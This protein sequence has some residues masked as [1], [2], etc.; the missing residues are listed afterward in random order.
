MFVQTFVMYKSIPQP[1]SR[2]AE[3]LENTTENKKL[4]IARVKF[5]EITS[6]PMYISSKTLKNTP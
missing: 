1:E 2:I 3:L 4:L 5:E 6:C